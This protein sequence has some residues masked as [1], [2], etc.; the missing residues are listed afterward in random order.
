MINIS[1]CDFPEFK[2]FMSEKYGEQVF[3]QGFNI[4]K[5]NQNIIFEEN[6]EQ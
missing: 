2:T 3:T 5:A 4:I 1:S 6:G